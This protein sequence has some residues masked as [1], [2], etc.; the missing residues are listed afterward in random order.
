MDFNNEHMDSDSMA[1]NEGF[2]FKELVSRVLNHWYAFLLSI[3]VF[4]GLAFLF[5]WHSQ[6]GYLVNSKVTVDDNSSSPGGQSLTNLMPS[7]FADLLDVPSNAYN[8][9]DILTSNNLMFKTI[10]AL[11]LNTTIYYK[12]PLKSTELYDEAPFNIHVTEKVDSIQDATYNVDYEKNFIHVTDHRDG[13]DT[14]IKNGQTLKL[15]Q[16]DLLF[17][18]KPKSL[19]G[20][21][22]FKITVVSADSKIIDLENALT[23]ALTDKKSTTLQLT[24]EYPN[25]KKGEVILQKLMD[26]YMQYNLENKIAI[27]D[28]TLKFVD[29]RLLVVN[30]EL[31]GLEGKFEKFKQEN[32][33]ADVDEQGK[34]LVQSVSDYYNKLNDIQIKISIIDDIDK[35]LNDPDNKKIIP[36]SFTVDD[37]VFGAAIGQYNELL[38]ERD[39]MALSYKDGN[40]VLQNLDSQLNNGRIS[41]LKSFNIYKKSLTLTLNDIK[42]KNSSLNAQVEASPHKERVFLDFT[43]KQSLEQQL[44]LYLLQKKEE[45]AI[46]KTST[47]SSARIIDPAKADYLPFKPRKLLIYALGFLFGAFAPLGFMLLRDSLNIKVTT[48]SDIEKGTFIPIVGEIG[49]NKNNNHLVVVDNSRSVLSEQFRSF[50]TNLQ[51]ILKDKISQVILITSSMSGEGKSFISLNLGNVF[52]ITGKKVLFIELDL[53]K[54]KLS[55]ALGMD[56]SNGFSNYIVSSSDDISEYIKK[57]Y[58]NETTFLL[59]SGA[60]PPNPSEL[61]L[62]TKFGEL[63]KQLR[64]EY[65]YIIIDSPPVG[66][67]SDALL[68][69]KYAD[70][71]LYV[72]RQN[73][74]LKSQLGIINDLV[75]SKKIKRAYLVI[76]DIQTKK[77]GYY[78]YGGYGYGYGYGHGYGYGYGYSEDEKKSSGFFKRLFRK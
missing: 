22:T 67:V 51:F 52:A 14:I 49:N 44:Y 77:A 70:V 53:R 21:G 43:M 73:Y 20:Y 55:A 28:S 50:R 40:P 59:S 17:T 74:T 7:D 9:L 38:V 36:S 42:A 10:K 56:N 65:D 48:K 39:K 45:T 33:L 31:S 47:I 18:P 58:F 23:V 75:R 4:V 6:T 15:D 35:F 26:L 63:L 61:L 29:N 54:P 71:T 13:V 68:I 16:V 60:I 30:D 78:G 66:L 41:L 27:A 24:L 69:E 2:D 57:V 12:Q 64:T 37:P 8:E 1:D 72:V 3:I 46:S 25:S 76:N 34:A 11:H 19:I 32:K 62:D 5:C